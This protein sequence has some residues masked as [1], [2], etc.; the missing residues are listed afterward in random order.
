[1]LRS[2]KSLIIW[3]LAA[4][5]VIFIVVQFLIPIFTKPQPKPEPIVEEEVYDYYILIDEETNEVLGHVSSVK[6]TTGD[7]YISENNKRYVVSKVVENRAYMHSFG[8]ADGGK[9]KGK[10]KDKTN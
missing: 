8:P 5:A 4:L 10:F 9:A 2:K 6:V 3:M 1:M 7:E